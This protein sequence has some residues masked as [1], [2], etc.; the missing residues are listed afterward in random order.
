MTTKPTA[1]SAST[2]PNAD[3]PVSMT[4]LEAALKTMDLVP[5]YTRIVRRGRAVEVTFMRRTQRPT[6]AD[7]LPPEL[8]KRLARSD[9][10]FGRDLSKPSPLSRAYDRERARA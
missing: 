9:A 6:L 10:W 2:S 4:D 1:S 5:E 8:A 7:R 3:E